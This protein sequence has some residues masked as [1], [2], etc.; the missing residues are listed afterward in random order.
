MGSYTQTPWPSWAY[1]E[2]ND[3]FSSYQQYPNYSAYLADSMEAYQT[4]HHHLVHHQQMSRATESKPRLSKEE[5]EVLEA[6]FQ[7]NH[8]P[9]SS[10]KKALAESM[11]VDNARINNWF[12]NRRAREK[13]ERNIR[14]YEAKQKMEK[15]KNDGGAGSRNLL[16]R[17][18]DLVASS[19]P[20][21]NAQGAHQPSNHRDAS[22]DPD[23]DSETAN[24]YFSDENSDIQKAE[25][26]SQL[27]DGLFGLPGTERRAGSFPHGG[28]YTS[29]SNGTS[30]LNE[31][32]MALST[33]DED[34]AYFLKQDH[35][36]MGDSSNAAFGFDTDELMGFPPSQVPTEDAN[37]LRSPPSIDI[38]SRRNRRP[39]PLAI[40]GSRSYTN[41]IPKTAVELSKRG[42]AMR[43]VASATGTMRISKPMSRSP[44][45]MSR[46]PVS[47]GPKGSNAPPTPDTPI[48]ANQPATQNIGGN[49]DPVNVLSVTDLAMR[50]P[51]LRTPP[52]TPGGLQNF[53]SLNSV[54]DM[55][56]SGNNLVTPSM[57]TFSGNFDG[58]AM[59][60]GVSN[61]VANANTNASQPQTPSFV[62]PMNTA[63]FGMTGGNAEYTW[64]GNM[65]SRNSSPAEEQQ[66][67]SQYLGIPASGFGMER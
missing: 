65:V 24:S 39:P 46:S 50:D 62:S 11:R 16:D 56:M 12:Q 19:A 38:A 2:V 44:F 59:S 35:P 57:A 29:P 60:L 52:T 32:D 30:D 8:K 28:D 55:P 40:H 17:K 47:T 63:S 25:V 36:A 15:D 42:D 54:Y 37:A 1:T 4:Q 14:E 53:F 26:P 45:Q 51:T 41:G 48:L 31:L 13:K 67:N 66:H 18:S 64:P 61:Y 9:N 43:R 22:L 27:P 21:P 6:E 7:K 5:V 10:T 3:P 58:S 34:S 23:Q 33:D 49:L 20:F